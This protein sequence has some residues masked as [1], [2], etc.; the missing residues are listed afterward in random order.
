MVGTARPC[1]RAV[2]LIGNARRSS[3][4]T[5]ATY[6]A[7]APLSAQKAS[8]RNQ[9]DALKEMSKV[10]ADTGEI[11][12]IK[13]YMPY[14]VTTNPRFAVATLLTAILTRRFS[15]VTLMT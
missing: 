6:A 15:R 7:E 1:P 3:V 12:S 10:V 2:S 4:R 13:S 14:D 8:A 5:L 9:L 11:D